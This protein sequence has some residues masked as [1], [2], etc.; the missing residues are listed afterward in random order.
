MRLF[1]MLALSALALPIATMPVQAQT[2]TAPVQIFPPNVPTPPRGEARVTVNYNVTDKLPS[3]VEAG[4][5][6][7]AQSKAHQ[8]VYEIAA[9]ECKLLLAVV[10]SECRV[11]LINVTS[12]VQRAAGTSNE[13]STAHKRQQ[14]LR[15]Q[16]EGA[17]RQRRVERNTNALRFPL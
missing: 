6:L 16:A 4:A 3:N 1:L 11:A 8:A 17:I 13:Q 15:N 10:A 9:E 2:Q 14:Y 12:T 5:L 7:V